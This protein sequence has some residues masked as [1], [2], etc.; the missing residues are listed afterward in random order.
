MMMV[1]SVSG[2]APGERETGGFE[3]FRASQDN[4]GK[5]LMSS[6]YV[7]EPVVGALSVHLV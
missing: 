2:I 6:H 5:D 1:A 7:S 3:T 4:S